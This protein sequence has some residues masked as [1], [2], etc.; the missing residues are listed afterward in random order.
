M[1][2]PLPLTTRLAFTLGD[3]AFNL[4]F[5]GT[6]LFLM[7]VY[8]DVF[9]VSPAVAGAIYALALLWD[10][11]TDPV[12][13]VIADRTRTR[14]GRYRPWVAIGAVPFAASYVLAYWNPGFTGLALVAWIAFTHCFLRTCYTVAGIPFSSLQARL[15]SDANERA[16]LAGFRMMG[17]ASGGLCVAF[18]TPL[19]VASSGFDREAHGYVLA[20]ALT[21]VIAIVIL[22][23]VVIVLKEPEQE[24]PEEAPQQLLG[25]LGDFFRQFAV[26]GPLVRVFIVITAIGVAV[27]MFSKNILYYFKYVLEAPESATLALVTPALMMLLM[28]PVWVLIAQRISKRRTWMIGASLA[29]IG[30]L[31]F[32]LNPVR[33]VGVVMAIIVVIALGTSSFGVLFW[34]MLPDTVEWGEAHQGVRHEAKVF[35]FAAFAQKAALGI[36]ALLLGLLLEGVGYVANQEQSETTIAGITTIMSLIPL[37]GLAV[38]VAAL[39]NY[40]IDAQ[41]HQALRDK[42]A[43]RKTGAQ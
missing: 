37:L 4:V 30:F 25:D 9:G 12:M 13:G 24:E 18:I 41:C 29:A 8:T 3:F 2:K 31:A 20:A 6:S 14:W 16:T 43:A 21:A 40:P 32:Y 22:T 15:T 39:W 23:Y 5:T 1:T 35:G 34:S 11:V 19:L 42:I 17:A 28:V 36:N 27:Y 7:Y 38:S 10:A 33:D 26:N